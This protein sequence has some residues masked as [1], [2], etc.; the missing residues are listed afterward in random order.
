MSSSPLSRR[1]LEELAELNADYQDLLVRLGDPEN[2]L[3]AAGRPADELRALAAE[4]DDA[5]RLA[6][7]AGRGLV[8]H[9][10]SAE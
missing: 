10:P 9:P 4:A 2:A 8:I 1:A 3:T 6:N 5:V 7:E